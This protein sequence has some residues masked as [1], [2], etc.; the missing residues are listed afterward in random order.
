[1]QPDANRGPGPAHMTRSATVR[2]PAVVVEDQDGV[3]LNPAAS[4]NV[5]LMTAS[6]RATT[7]LSAGEVDI[8]CA[9]ALAAGGPV[10]C[11]QLS[12]WAVR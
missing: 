12:R 9:C 1:M 7:A 5:K 2:P 8:S 11:G 6:S 3:T 4:P 10:K